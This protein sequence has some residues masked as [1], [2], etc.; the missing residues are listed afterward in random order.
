MAKVVTFKAKEVLGQD[1]SVMDSN[2]NIKKLN[3]CLKDIYNAMTKLDGAKNS[4]LMDYNEAISEQVIKGTADLL[5]LG[6]EDTDKLADM[7][8]SEIFNFYSK[9]VNE[10]TGM[11]VPSVRAMEENANAAVKDMEE[12]P[13]PD[14]DE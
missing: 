5:K 13:K 6:K 11:T 14:S 1:F 8:Y 9:T 2:R 4:T 10:F 7:S 12:D 3:K